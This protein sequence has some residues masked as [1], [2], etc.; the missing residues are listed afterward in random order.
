M[1]GIYAFNGRT[2]LFIV[3]AGNT[4]EITLSIFLTFYSFTSY[5]YY[6]YR[7]IPCP[8]PHDNY[9]RE[10]AAVSTDEKIVSCSFNTMFT[11]RH[12]HKSIIKN[13]FYE[14]F[15]LSFYFSLLPLLT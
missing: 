2:K 14:P 13:T 9:T 4:V 15:I 1:I 3:L 7:K 5:L 11:T 10:K 6:T 12:S 8:I